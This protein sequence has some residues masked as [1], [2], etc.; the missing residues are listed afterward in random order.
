MLKGEFRDATRA[1][2]PLLIELLMSKD[3]GVSSSA[4]SV[5]AKL[6]ESGEQHPIMILT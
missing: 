4:I 2:I 1:V 3:E 6:A 5:L